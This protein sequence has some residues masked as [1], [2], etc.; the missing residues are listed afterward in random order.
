MLRL[1]A[2]S[3][4]RIGE[5]VQDMNLVLYMN[6]TEVAPGLLKQARNKGLGEEE[7]VKLKAAMKVLHRVCTDT[8]LKTSETLLS[9]Y[10]DDPPKTS[11]ELSILVQA[12]KAELKS[13]LFVYIPDYRSKYFE[14]DFEWATLFPTA[15]TEAKEASNCFAFGANTAS[16]FHSM[17]ALEIGLHALAEDV[18]ILTAKPLTD[19]NWHNI[20]DAIE[21]E[22][23]KKRGGSG[24]TSSDPKIMFWS[25]AASEFFMFKEAW[26]NQ[27]MHVR[28]V[29]SESEAQRII[30]AVDLFMRRLAT[31]LAEPTGALFGLSA[32]ALESMPGE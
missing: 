17:R 10:L 26:R 3:Y 4:I 24:M 31:K 15:A 9:Q 12:V 23:K 29:Y 18:G 13:R 8:D 22:I 6:E 30:D 14:R 1:H 7:L 5:I 2:H 19:M 28:K 21:T 11:G 20:I 27:T 25:E 32:V 16:V